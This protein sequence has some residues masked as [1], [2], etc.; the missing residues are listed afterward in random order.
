MLLIDILSIFIGVFFALT[1]LCLVVG[2]L[3]ILPD[4]GKG[5]VIILFAVAV[6]G[7][8]I[9]GLISPSAPPYPTE[10]PYEQYYQDLGTPGGY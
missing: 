9:N 4:W 2:F 1:L 3:S 5:L 10:D 8:F 7:S 6:L